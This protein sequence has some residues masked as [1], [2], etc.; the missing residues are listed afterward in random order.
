MVKMN[1]HCNAILQN[2][3]PQ[4]C[5]DLESFTIPCLLGSEK[6]DKALCDS[7]A[8]INLI[9]LSV[10]RK[11][12]SELGVIKSIPVSLQLADQ[13]TI[14]PEGIIEDILVRV[15]KF[16]FP[17]DFIVVNMEVNKKVPIILGRPFLCTGRTNLD[18]YEWKLMLVVGNEKVVFQMKRM[19]KYPNDEASAYSFFKLDV[20]GELAKKSKFDKLVGDIL[21]WCII[22]SSK[23][24]DEDP[25]IKK[26]AEA[27]E[28]EDQVVDE[29][30]LKKEASK[31]SVELKVLPTH[32]KYVFLETNNFF[33]II[34]AYLTG[35]DD[36]F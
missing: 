9:P 25:E 20:V 23:E 18:I 6:F 30:E 27:L 29:E 4:K 1:A 31:P 35:T 15:G 36:Q 3:I 12:E 7:G 11:L 21:E 26:E 22:Q 2:Q 28:T 10:F 19:M 8:F 5:R 14:L 17:I 34:S 16:A 33:V 24:D 32:L 13:T